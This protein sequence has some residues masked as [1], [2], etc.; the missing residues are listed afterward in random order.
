E[1]TRALTP[2][3]FEGLNRLKATGLVAKVRGEGLV[4]GIECADCGER[5]SKQVAVEVVKAAYL[6]NE[7]GDG[8][9]LLGPLA[10]NVVGIS[11]PNVIAEAQARDSLAL[12][13]EIVERLAERINAVPVK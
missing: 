10:G 11:P 3:F 13:H 5:T 12:L 6:G 2:V 8:V 9:H 4:F 1:H 7:A